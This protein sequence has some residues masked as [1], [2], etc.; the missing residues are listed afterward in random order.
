MFTTHDFQFDLA[1]HPHQ[2][3]YQHRSTQEESWDMYHAHQG[4]EFI[5]V[6]QGEGLVI[7]DQHIYAF[8]P[9]TLMY[10]QPFQLHRVKAELA[11][12][13]SYIRSK[14]LFEPSMMDSF[15]DHFDELQQFFRY[16]WQEQLHSQIID[17]AADTQTFQMIFNL[18]RHKLLKAARPAKPSEF[19]LFIMIF[20][21]RLQ[22]YWQQLEN[23]RPN[24]RLR[25]VHYAEEIMHWIDAH[26]REEFILDNLAKDLHL[27]NY[28]L[29]HLFR[30]ATG[31][32]ITEYL[33]FRRLREACILLTTT[34]AS[35]QEISSVVGIGNVSY[36]CQLF[37][38]KLGNTPAKYRAQANPK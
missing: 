18:Y 25:H 17:L 24:C 28:H 29:S 19:A 13:Q 27:S 22:D 34:P 36:F 20:L 14:F 10:F 8:Q 38:K 5:F 16:L 1:R 12:T 21:N 32:S 9:G 23:T 2:F 11:S 26:F 6:H 33:M 15:L 4:M 35:I 37:K 7:I 3:I 31:S 30:K